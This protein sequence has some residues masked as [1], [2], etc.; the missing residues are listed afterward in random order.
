MSSDWGVSWGAAWGGA[1]GSLAPPQFI[2]PA[3]Q[4]RARQIS[5]DAVCRM[6]GRPAVEFYPVYVFG[7]GQIKRIYTEPV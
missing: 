1:W 3:P 4:V 7:G 2:A 6:A 5:W